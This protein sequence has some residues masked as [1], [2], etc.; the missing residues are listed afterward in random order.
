MRLLGSWGRG[1]ARPGAEAGAGDTRTACLPE[2]DVD[3][4]QSAAVRWAAGGSGCHRKARL[5]QEKWHFSAC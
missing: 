2:H 3:A 4:V 1:A 5:R